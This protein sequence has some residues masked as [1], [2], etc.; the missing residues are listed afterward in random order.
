MSSKTHDSRMTQDILANLRNLG[1][2][3]VNEDDLIFEGSKFVLPE[4]LTLGEAIKFLSAKQAE[5][6]QPFGFSRTFKYRPWDG[7]YAVYQVFRQVFG[8]VLGKETRSFFGSNPPQFIDID[9]GPGQQAQVPWGNLE[10]PILPGALFSLGGEDGG[11]DGLLFSLSVT[12]PKKYRAEIEGIFRLV[13]DELVERSIY[14]GKAFDGQEMPEFLDL[15]GVDASKVIYNADTRSQLDANVWAPLVYRT[16]HEELG[17]PLKRAVLLTGPYGTGKSLTGRLTAKVAVDNGWTFIYARPGKD[18]IR[19]AMSTARLYQPAVVFFEDIDNAAVSD[20]DRDAV[21]ELLDV[22]DGITAKDTQILAVMTTNHPEKIHK[23]MLRPGR[24]D[25]VI[26]IGGLEPKA[27]TQM[28]KTFVPSHLLAEDID[29]PQVG[30]SMD[31][32]LPAFIHEAIGRA[33]RYAIA[34]NGEGAKVLVTEDFI[35]AAEGLRPQLELMEAA[36]EDV[37]DR[38]LETATARVVDQALRERLDARILNGEH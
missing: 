5:E 20:Q 13:E 4:R 23:G 19:R 25:A 28:V 3:R 8:S 32:F 11:E 6:E 7:A 21:T 9:I 36:G 16:S 17:L 1:G 18:D 10:V 14:R 30:A 34:R 29:Y 15:S 26:H 24:L 22:F 37:A 31:G 12:A 2:K 27:I 33:L 38:S 35:E